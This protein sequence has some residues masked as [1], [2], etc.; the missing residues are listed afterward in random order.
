MGSGTRHTVLEVV[1]S[2]E[3]I[4]G[5]RFV[6]DFMPARKADVSSI[7]LDISRISAELGWKPEVDFEEGLR[8]TLATVSQ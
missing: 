6:I 2:I 4:L 3:S 7:A 5:A 8:R 1:R